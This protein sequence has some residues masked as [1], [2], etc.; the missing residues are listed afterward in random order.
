MES[1]GNEEFYN[2]YIIF[3]RQDAGV[4]W[5]YNESTMTL[6]ISGTGD[7]QDYWWDG[8]DVPPWFDLMYDEHIKHIIIENGITKIGTECFVYGDVESVTLPESLNYINF[9]AFSGIDIVYYNGTETNWASVN[10]EPYNDGILNADIIF[11]K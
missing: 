4:S 10:I 11:L 8:E 2:A 7:M 3:L 6:T 9:S 1:L 5:E